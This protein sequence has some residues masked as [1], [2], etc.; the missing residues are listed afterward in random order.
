VNIDIVGT[1]CDTNGPC[2]ANNGQAIGVSRPTGRVRMKLTGRIAL[3]TGS[4]QGIGAAI[5]M[6]LA[7][8]GADVAVT[9]LDDEPAAAAVAA[10]IRQ[11]GRRV[12]LI[13]ADIAQL[14]GI[15]S[16]VA[17]TVRVLGAPDILVNNAG[18]FP[19]V[20]LLEMRESDWDYV[21][22]INL[23]AGCFATIAFVKALTAAGKRAGSVINISSQAI[24]GAV[25][26][27]H[28]SA[29]KGGVV[30]MTRA[31]ALELAPQNIR[32][33]AIAP[34]TT[35]TAQPRYGNT[36][37]ELIEMAKTIP[38]GGKMLMPDQIA[39]TAVFLASEDASAITGQVLH[40]NGG[41]YM[42]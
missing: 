30:S 24:R 10:R 8:E 18:V 14:A 28:Y 11:A 23:K 34:G 37:A 41:S 2:A 21:L 1:D 13:C 31:M 38:L 35:D 33:N 20:K 39:R 36:E 17:D 6:A 4:Q 27:V 3:V 32:V 22:D 12:H 26:G 19:R 9:W 16:M 15:E 40:V 25:R 42:P 7:E 29:S 5:A